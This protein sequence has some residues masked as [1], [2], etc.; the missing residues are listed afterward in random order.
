MKDDHEERMA[1]LQERLDD[2]KKNMDEVEEELEV[3]RRVKERENIREEIRKEKAEQRGEDY[4]KPKHSKKEEK[5][6]DRKAEKKELF[7]SRSDDDDNKF[8][9]D[10]F[11]HKDGKG[12]FIDSIKPHLTL[13]NLITAAI[14][15]GFLIGLAFL[16]NYVVGM[17]SIYKTNEGNLTAI[18]QLG[19]DAGKQ[20]IDTTTAKAEETKTE[21]NKTTTIDTKTTETKTENKTS[22]TTTNTSSKTT[23]PP[24]AAG[25]PG[26]LTLDFDGVGIETDESKGYGRLLR[27]K[28]KIL[29]KKSDV[30]KPLT[31]EYSV[32]EEGIATSPNK[33]TLPNI[34]QTLP[35]NSEVAWTID[36]QSDNK[37][38]S[39]ST[40]A[41]TATKLKVTLVLRDSAKKEL[42][43]AI[44][45][46]DV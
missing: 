6:D 18:Q 15:I 7:S 8:R 45:E 4:S 11:K 37:G 21:D 12:N 16:I 39:L 40:Y 41:D 20:N 24:V 9:Y 22:S 36:Y 38:T 27:I 43:R 3:E 23:I 44:K 14:V 34:M 17:T 19:G 46:F 26:Q 29:N 13:K 42:A 28:Y 35:A 10:D 25:T 2:M 33:F 30:V 31:I 1:Q 5:R 32:T